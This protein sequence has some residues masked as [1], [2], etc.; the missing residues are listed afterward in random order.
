MSKQKL[1]SVTSG[2]SSQGRL[3]RRNWTYRL[4]T[5]KGAPEVFEGQIVFVDVAVQPVSKIV[6]I[7]AEIE[8]H[9]NLLRSG[10]P[11]TITINPNRMVSRALRP[12]NKNHEKRL[13]INKALD[14][15]VS[16]P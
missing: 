4:T 5:L 9:D 12:I 1:T 11:A 15:T 3:C 13:K 16:K 14:R 8:N 10:L 7:W 2:K 6:R